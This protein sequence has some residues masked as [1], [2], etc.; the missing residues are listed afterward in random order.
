MH[1]HKPG[2]KDF[3]KPTK[4]RYLLVEN[5]ALSTEPVLLNRS[6]IAVENLFDSIDSS[7]DGLGAFMLRLGPKMRTQGRDPKATGGQ[8]HLILNGSLE[9]DGI[10]YPKWSVVY[11]NSHDAALEPCAGAG[12]AE[13]L[14]L[15]FPRTEE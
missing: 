2:Y 4:K 13:T 10:D 14:V 8:F 7:D 12:G 3:L 15:E 1:L 5:I 6:E 9:L 11:A